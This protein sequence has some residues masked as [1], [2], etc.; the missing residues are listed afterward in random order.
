MYKFWRDSPLQSLIPVLSFLK[1]KHELSQRFYVIDGNGI[2]ASEAY[3]FLNNRW[4]ERKM[5]ANNRLLQHSDT[6]IRGAKA[7]LKSTNG[8]KR[9]RLPKKNSE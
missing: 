4:M 1:S 7:V 2:T 8:K 5:Y 3:R 6:E 9:N